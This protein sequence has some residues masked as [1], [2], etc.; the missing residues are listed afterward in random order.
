MVTVSSQW[1]LEHEGPYLPPHGSEGD[2]AE[3]T[4][5]VPGSERVGV[6]EGPGSGPILCPALPGAGGRIPGSI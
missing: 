4:S 2:E 5:Q 1:V 6:P 3:G